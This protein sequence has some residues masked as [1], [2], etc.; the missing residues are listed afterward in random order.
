[1][2]IAE[3][4]GEV[5]G[6]VV[7]NGQGYADA[8]S[9]APIASSLEMPILLTKKDGVPGSVLDYVVSSAIEFSFVIG[10]N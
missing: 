10:G 7:A 2:K 6:A 9:I 3:E 4:L 8:L 1:M 5:Y